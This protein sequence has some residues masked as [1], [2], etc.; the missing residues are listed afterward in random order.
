MNLL[1]FIPIVVAVVV[2]IWIFGR[3][4][5]A[6]KNN[7]TGDRRDSTERPEL[8]GTEQHKHRQ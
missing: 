1:V 3:R 2:L 6:T 8:T 5:G 4:S 7:G